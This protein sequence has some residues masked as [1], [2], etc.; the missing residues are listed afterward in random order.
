VKI[1][2]TKHALTKGI[3]CREAHIPSDTPSMAIVEGPCMPQYFHGKNWHY[4][5]AQAVA[6]AKVMQEKKIKNLQKQLAK[7]KAL[8]FDEDTP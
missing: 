1:W 8:S 2:I 6:Q 7:V 3:L 5:R 4:S